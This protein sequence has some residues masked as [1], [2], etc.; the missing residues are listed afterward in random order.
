MALKSQHLVPVHFQIPVLGRTPV[1]LYTALHHLL[2][3]QPL[4]EQQLQLAGRPQISPRDHERVPPLERHRGA[5]DVG[6]HRVRHQHV[7]RAP[8]VH[9][10]QLGALGRACEHGAVVG[11]LAER[12]G[13]AEVHRVVRAHAPWRRGRGDAELGREQRV[14]LHAPL[15]RVDVA[16]SAVVRDVREGEGVRDV[17]GVEGGGCGNEEKEED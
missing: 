16:Q 15:G 3:H 1:H 17:G 9:E 5:R 7:G 11:R 10:Q 12:R 4:R 2:P 13:E 14:R 8:G 6:A